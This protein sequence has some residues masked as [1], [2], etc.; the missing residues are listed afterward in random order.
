MVVGVPN[1]GK[2]A[3][4]NSIHQIA[5]SRFPGKM[6]LCL[7]VLDMRCLELCHSIR[8][9]INKAIV[10]SYLYICDCCLEWLWSFYIVQE[11]TKRA[12]VGP[13]PGVTQDIAGYKV[14]W[15]ICFSFLT[16]LWCHLQK[17]LYNF[18][19]WSSTLRILI[20]W[21]LMF[22][23]HIPLFLFWS[24]IWYALYVHGIIWWQSVL[25]LNLD[26]Y[27]LIPNVYIVVC[28]VYQNFPDRLFFPLFPFSHKLKCSLF[29]SVQLILYFTFPWNYKIF[30]W[31][32]IFS[33]IDEQIAHR[34]SIYVLDTPGVLVP[35]ISDIETGLKLALAG[36][37]LFQTVFYL[38]HS[39]NS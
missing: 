12:T 23:L 11:K 38:N 37:T 20:H 29:S 30:L 26:T 35:S 13:L 5:L 32:Q 31:S 25:N 3:L 21:A 36:L 17:N 6:L 9:L 34:P 19:P 39:C 10:L 7:I 1:V 18:L 27:L 14:D 8:V 28:D 33:F 15:I 2:S 22:Y 4:I 24:S 16:F